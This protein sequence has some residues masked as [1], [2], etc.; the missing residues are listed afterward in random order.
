M[1]ELPEKHKMPG[2]PECPYC[3]KVSDLNAEFQYLMKFSRTKP[4]GRYIRSEKN[5]HI[6]ADSPLAIRHHQNWRAKTFEL[7]EK[8]TAEDLVS[9]APISISSKDIPKIR[10]ILLEAIAEISKVVEASPP[11]EIT[12]LGIDWLRI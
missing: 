1:R 3:D 6:E 7:H 10:K 2:K 4:N 5:T 11:E 9:T 8:M 12:Y